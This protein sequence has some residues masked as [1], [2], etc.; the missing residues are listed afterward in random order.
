MKRRTVEAIRRAWLDVPEDL[1]R[2][3]LRQAEIVRSPM[4]REYWDATKQAMDGDEGPLR[5]WAHKHTGAK[6]DAVLRVRLAQHEVGDLTPRETWAVVAAR[7]ARIKKKAKARDLEGRVAML[8]GG[9]KR[10]SWMDRALGFWRLSGQSYEEVLLKLIRVLDY[11]LGDS[12]SEAELPGKIASQIRREGIEM[13]HEPD[14]VLAQGIDLPAKVM[15]GNADEQVAFYFALREQLAQKVNAAKLSNQEQESWFFATL[16]G[17]VEAAAVLGR[18]A[19]Q[20]A[21]EKF[22][23]SKKLHQ[24]S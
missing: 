13:P 14:K 5:A 9:I 17:N 20:V 22:R 15:E 3:L 2:E 10:Y 6:P 19:N 1:K 12:Y 8:R 4:Y 18:P 23:A 7:S 11:E 24:A 21:Q 16:F